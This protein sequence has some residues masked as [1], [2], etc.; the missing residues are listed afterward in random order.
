MAFM[1]YNY[2][3]ISKRDVLISGHESPRKIMQHA[4]PRVSIFGPA[5]FQLIILNDLDKTP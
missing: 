1:A 5:L 3:Y 2:G 4:V